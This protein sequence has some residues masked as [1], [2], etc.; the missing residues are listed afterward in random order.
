[1]AIENMNL[2]SKSLVLHRRVYFAPCVLQYYMVVFSLSLDLTRKVL[3][4]F[5]VPV[6]ECEFALNTILDDLQPDPWPIKQ[7][8]RP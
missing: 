7:G 1:M 6:S 2:S 4:K 5:F 8:N 3:Q